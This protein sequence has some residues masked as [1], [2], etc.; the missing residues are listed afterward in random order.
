MEETAGEA[1]M[2]D[3]DLLDGL[4]RH[5]LFAFTVRTFQTVNPGTPFVEAWHLDAITHQLDRVRRGATRRLIINQPPRSLKSLT[6]SVAFVAFLL[7]HDPSLKI[8]VV[9]YSEGLAADLARQFRQVVASDWYRRIFPQ[10][11]IARD[12]ALEL[13]TSEGGGRVGLSMGGSLTGRGADLIILD[14]PMNAEQAT[15]KAARLAVVNAYRGSLVSRLNEKTKGAM[16]LVMQ[17]LHLEDLTGVLLEDGGW[18]HLCLPAIA[19]ERLVIPLGCGEKHVFA[20]GDALQPLRE[21][22][23]VLARVKAELGSFAFCAQYLQSPVPPEGNL[24]KAEWIRTYGH[25][26]AHDSDG[27]VIQS[28]D[29]A[30]KPG[31]DND[32]SVCTTW[33]KKGTDYYLLDVFRVRC[34][35]PTLERH[36]V[37]RAHQFGTSEVLIE[38]T[39][40]GTGLI[41]MLRDKRARV[42]AIG[43]IP[44][45]DKETRMAVHSSTFEAGQ[46]FLPCTAPWKDD[47]L[48]ELLA[49]PNARYDDQVD[50]TSQF[51]QWAKEQSRRRGMISRSSNLY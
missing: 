36:V 14:D 6:C 27:R 30:L 28:W 40:S 22:H 20:I 33:L 5:D 31:I 49:F 3:R 48:A 47:Y 21:G 24:L 16:I 50:S 4:L 11:R 15:S 32:F 1:I 2:N 7:G 37:S 23:D 44:K 45:G 38:D 39:G 26:P 12:T 10:L 17:R 43:I 19:Q 41:Q 42:R 9:S 29:T 8:W 51:L 13:V 18:E 46:V 34:D 35:F 25:P